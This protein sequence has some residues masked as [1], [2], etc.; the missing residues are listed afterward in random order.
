MWFKNLFIYRLN[1]WTDTAET[2]DDKLAKDA[3]APC[4]GG[5]LMTR[6]W[7]SPKAD[8]LPLVH[9]CGKH[10]LISLGME[11]RLLPASVIKQFTAA[12]V[13]DIEERE[14]YKPGRKQVKE[15]KEAVTTELIP[16]AFVIRSRTSAWLDPVGG[17]LFIDAGSAT[18]AE[19]LMGQLLKSVAGLSV[20]PLRTTV[21]PSTAMTNWLVDGDSPRQFSVDQDCELRG[22]GEQAATVRYVKHAL[23]SDEI[24]RHIKG[25]KVVTR[26]AMTWADRVSFTLHENLQIKKIAPLDVLKETADNDPDSD[27]FDTDVALMTGELPKLL[28]ALVQALEGEMVTPAQKVA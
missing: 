28:D 2:L 22:R 7:V 19:D 18:K 27:A 23:D 14:G 6:G 3:L 5:D 11:K 10:L 12:R 9:S 26:L 4:G 24:V 25:G 1:N 15:I 16:R 17:W 8:G 13:A 20:T 21:S